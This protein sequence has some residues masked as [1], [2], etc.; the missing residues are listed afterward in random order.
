MSTI[1]IADMDGTL[2]NDDG[3][4]SETTL[5]TLNELIEQ[6]VLFSIC[7]ARSIASAFDLVKDIKFT[8]PVVLMNGVFIYDIINDRSI[9]HFPIEPSAA[10]NIFKLY[11]KHDI[12]PFM[13]LFSDYLEVVFEKLDNDSVSSF[14]ASR[15][16]HYRSFT[17]AEKLYV[18]KDKNIVYFSTLNRYDKLKPLHDEMILLEGVQCAFYPDTYSDGDW[19]FEAFSSKAGKGV[20]IKTLQEHVGAQRLTVFGDNYNDIPMFKAADE[21]YAMG[22]AVEELKK[23]ATKVIATNNDDGVANFIKSQQNV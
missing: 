13:Y 1:Y 2:L 10:E 18:P 21:A 23:I 17:K 5:K 3:I 20:G 9:K 6:G 22:N 11:D 16:K 15:K 14:Y 7:T 4:V 19:F 12:H 8:T